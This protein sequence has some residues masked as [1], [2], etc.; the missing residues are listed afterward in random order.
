MKKSKPFWLARDICGCSTETIKSGN[1][2]CDNWE[3][4]LVY[5][6]RPLRNKNG[7]LNTYASECVHELEP[8]EVTTATPFRLECGK[9]SRMVLAPADRKA[10][11]TFWIHR[12]LFFNEEGEQCGGN[13][14]IFAEKPKEFR[15]DGTLYDRAYDKYIS[16]FCPE[17]FEKVTGIILQPNQ[18]KLFR[19]QKA[20][21]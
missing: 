4:Y 6:K 10:K 11:D 17:D 12:Q 7:W 1:C 20:S 21:A 15:K 2:E 19:L 5:D 3:E 8:H 13:Y 9:Q 16:R 14:M 18:S